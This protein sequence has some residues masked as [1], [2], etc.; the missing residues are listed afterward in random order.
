MIIPNYLYLSFVILNLG[1]NMTLM[2]NN[3]LFI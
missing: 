3:S 1:D 2:F